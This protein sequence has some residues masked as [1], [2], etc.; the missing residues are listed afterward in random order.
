MFFAA[1]SS[2]EG[3]LDESGYEVTFGYLDWLWFHS[4]HLDRSAL[5]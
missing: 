4:P 1:V 3:A 2:T 5:R